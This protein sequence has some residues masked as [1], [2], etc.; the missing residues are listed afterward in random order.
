M[1]KQVNL[2]NK[3]KIL[4]IDDEEFI[5]ELVKDILE[6]E[7]IDSDLAEDSN[8]AIEFVKNNEYS[9]IFLDKNLNGENIKD[10]ISA[11]KNNKCNAKIIIITGEMFVDEEYLQNVG[12]DDYLL[13]PFDF[14][15]L[16]NKVKE[17]LE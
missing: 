5:R 17:H 16:I 11:I 3:K 14:E 13:K 1:E 6:I 4:V 2:N 12:A 8:K 9:L 7:G 10:L 15:S